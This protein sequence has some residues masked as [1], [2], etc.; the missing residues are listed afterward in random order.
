MSEQPDAVT[1]VPGLP[2]VPDGPITVEA[3]WHNAPGTGAYEMPP[4]AEVRAY[5]TA[6]DGTVTAKVLKPPAKP[7]RKTGR[8]AEAKVQ[9]AQ[10]AG[11]FVDEVQAPA[12]A[13]AEQDP[14]A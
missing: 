5:D 6:E 7:T 3:P 9:G 13:P 11:A 8:Q 2:A 4:V 1:P 14:E 10:L 12:E